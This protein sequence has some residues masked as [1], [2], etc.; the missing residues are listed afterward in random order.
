MFGDGVLYGVVFVFGV[1]LH[2]LLVGDI[3]EKR[4]DRI[5]R[6][7]AGGDYEKFAEMLAAG[8]MTKDDLRDRIKKQ[9]AVDLYTS[10]KVDRRIN[11][12]PGA[13]RD[14][15]QANPSEFSK[16]TSVRL[17]M[18][19]IT[20]RDKSET[21]YKQRIETITQ[22]IGDGQDFLT[23]ARKLSDS[24]N[25]KVADDVAW[26]EIKDMPEGFRNALKGLNKGQMAG[27]VEINGNTFFL[28]IRE[29]RGGETPEFA[30]VRDAV[31][32]KLFEQERSKRYKAF[33]KKLRKSAY[34][35]RFNEDH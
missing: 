2:D 27:P 11:I 10:Q 31:E 26:L 1:G 21:E 5:V 33:I 19:I 17:Q 20:S 23:F 4:I 22:A 14:Y 7:E 12:S 15:F 24:P 29:T 9:L 8:R 30:D 3:V 25:R 13:V 32:Q 16:P 34:I 35:R 6:V 28:R 18:I